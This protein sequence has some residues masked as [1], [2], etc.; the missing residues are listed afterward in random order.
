MTRD[1]AD[2]GKTEPAPLNQTNKPKG[3][4]RCKNCVQELRR[5]LRPD[6]VMF[7][8][9]QDGYSLT[10]KQATQEELIADQVRAIE[11][12]YPTDAFSGKSAWGRS[13]DTSKGSG[14]KPKQNPR[15]Q[16]PFE[17]KQGEKS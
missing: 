17:A 8:N 2:C 9:Y 4:W 16:P 12:K 5:V 3:P 13:G 15:K 11:K 10:S 14:L 7:I 1:C 6:G